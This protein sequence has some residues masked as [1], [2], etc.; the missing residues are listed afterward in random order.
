MKGK[1]SGKC[2]YKT[3]EKKESKM[4]KKDSKPMKKGT[5]MGRASGKGK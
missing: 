1:P 5:G 4:D 3:A 2:D